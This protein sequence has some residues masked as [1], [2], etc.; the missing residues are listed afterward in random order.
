[1][2]GGSESSVQTQ[3]ANKICEK[4]QQ[5]FLIDDGHANSSFP[6]IFTSSTCE[7]ILFAEVSRYRIS[8][9]WEISRRK[10]VQ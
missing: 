4:E 1:M 3:L 10:N 8:K 9:L 5:G 2:W 6:E 7:E